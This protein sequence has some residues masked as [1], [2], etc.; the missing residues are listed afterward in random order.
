MPLWEP[1]LV[2]LAGQSFCALTFAPT[3]ARLRW[4]KKER[5]FTRVLVGRA[6]RAHLHPQM[7][8]PHSTRRKHRAAALAGPGNVSGLE[9]FLQRFSAESRDH[10]RI[11]YAFDAPELLE[12][13]EARAVAHERGPVE[14]A[15]HAAFLV[16]EAGLVERRFGVS[17][18]ERAVGARGETVEE[19]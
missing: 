1:I 7:E 5:R 3:G 19:T 18:E 11:R 13:E 17:L 9:E 10:F 8:I 15:H 12:A 16:G 14:L 4:Q 6:V 2:R